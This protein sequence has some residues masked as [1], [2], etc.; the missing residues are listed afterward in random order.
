LDYRAP[1][2]ISVVVDF[3]SNI[4][5]SALYFL[6]RNSSIKVYLFEPV[7]R[8]IERLR[9]N[10]KGFENRYELKECAVGM[11]E[12]QLDFAC[13]DTGRYGGLIKEGAPYF[14]EWAPQKIIPVKVV[15]VNQVLDQVLSRHESVDILKIDVEGY[16]TKILSHLKTDVLSRIGRIYVETEDDQKVLGFSSESISGLTRYY[17]LGSPFRKIGRSLL[18]QASI[19]P[20]II[21]GKIKLSLLHSNGA[22]FQFISIF[23]SL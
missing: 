20:C 3:G 16:E 10:L 23:K 5:I 17:F 12:G 15:A 14:S 7:P 1:K 21:T 8:N 2:N 6:T 18:D 19:P 11:E 4:G 22:F 13:D 9:D